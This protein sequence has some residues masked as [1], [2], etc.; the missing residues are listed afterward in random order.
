MTAKFDGHYRI[1][2]PNHALLHRRVE[3]HNAARVEMV[4]IAHLRMYLTY[5]ERRIPTKFQFDISFYRTLGEIQYGEN[6][7]RLAGVV[8]RQEKMTDHQDLLCWKS[9]LLHAQFC[10]I[11][12]QPLSDFL[13]N[14]I[15]S[16]RCAHSRRGY[17]VP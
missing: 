16:E 10:Y 7:A 12:G 13:Q 9:P 3:S 14:L 6:L 4:L 1:P 17:L 15:H 2:V 5:S 8:E 11:T